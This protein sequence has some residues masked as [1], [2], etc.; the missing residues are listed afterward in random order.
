MPQLYLYIDAAHERS[1]S[2]QMAHYEA[3]I[4]QSGPGDPGPDATPE[5][6]IRYELEL[7]RKLQPMSADEFENRYHQM[8]ADYK[9]AIEEGYEDES[10]IL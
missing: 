2:E 4:E 1:F 10:H 8:V 6:R 9:K 7:A 3:Y 5:E